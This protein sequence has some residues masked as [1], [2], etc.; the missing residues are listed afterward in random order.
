MAEKFYAKGPGNEGYIKNMEVVAYCDAD[1]ADLFQMAL[2]KTKDQKYYLYCASFAACGIHIIDVTD[3]E[4]PRTVKHIYPYDAVKWPTTTTVKIQVCDEL[5]LVSVS[6]G[7]GAWF[8]GSIG[9]PEGEPDAGLLIYSLKNDPENPELLSFWSCGV[10]N[11]E[12]VHRFYYNGGRYV[13]MPAQTK[14]FYGLTYRII[15]IA[16]PRNP[17]DVSNF[18]LPEQYVNGSLDPVISNYDISVPHDP[19][20]HAQSHL[21]QPFIRGDLA[22]CGYMGA[23]MVIVDISDITSPRL[24]SRLPLRPTVG[25]RVGGSKCHTAMP[26]GDRPFLV[27]SIEGDRIQTQREWFM[28]KYGAQA[29]NPLMMV[30]ISDPKD[31]VIVAFFPYPE[32]PEGFPY[33][34]FNFMGFKHQLP[35]GPHN[36]HEPMSNKP[37]LENDPNRV[38][39]CYFHAGMR[40]YDV[41][42]PYYIKE[43]AYFIPPNPEK[44]RAKFANWEGPLVA[45]TEDCVVDDRGYIFM[46][47]LQDGLYVLRCLV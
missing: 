8:G 21:H 7:G 46:D 26:L 44:P 39:C 10:P 23:G 32:V 36:I 19:V 16:D 29:V 45:T 5:M 14:G 24:I 27:L 6:S 33:P 18:F 9:E 35:F 20:F 4:H 3:A 1:G 47:T 34:N 28:E 15:D 41:S 40:V 42:D 17:K 38:Y 30:D 37:W 11:S 2:H 22:Y 13:H 25:S 12:G 31:P 43:I